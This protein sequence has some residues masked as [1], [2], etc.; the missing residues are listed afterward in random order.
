MRILGGIGIGSTVA[1]LAIA[2]LSVCLGVA[3]GAPPDKPNPNALTFKEAAKQVGKKVTMRMEVR[4]TSV[5]VGHRLH[6]FPDPKIRSGFFINIPQTA[7]EAFKKVNIDDPAT[8]YKGKTIEVTGQVVKSKEGAK[9]VVS[10]PKEIKVV[11]D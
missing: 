11:A 6:A 3:A 4:S 5:L 2:V 8:F 10:D 7:F 9:I 1:L